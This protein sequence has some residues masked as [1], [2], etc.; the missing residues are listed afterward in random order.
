MPRW[1][2]PSRRTCAAGKR[3]ALRCRAHRPRCPSSASVSRRASRAW[4]R[5]GAITASSWR[6]SANVARRSGRH[7]FP[8]EP[9]KPSDQSTASWRIDWVFTLSSLPWGSPTRARRA[10]RSRAASWPRWSCT[11]CCTDDR[12]STRETRERTSW[13]RKGAIGP[14]PGSFDPCHE[15]HQMIADAV[16]RQYG[17]RVAYAVTAD[18]VHKPSLRTSIFSIGSH[19]FAKAGRAQSIVLTERILCSST[20]PGSSPA[21]ESPLGSTRWFA[22]SIPPGD[23][24]GE[25]LE[26]FERWA[27][28]STSSADL[29]TAAG[30]RSMTSDPRPV[31]APLRIGRGSS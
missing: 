6:P 3:R 15:G 24:L 14:A 12:C 13:E 25:M 28:G 18:P 30:R 31:Q 27:P 11:P 22:C 26:T 4:C 2:S 21:R 7:G 16:E 5:I 1:S 17:R 20:R 29:S 9:A 10:W 19:P 8:R 23:Q